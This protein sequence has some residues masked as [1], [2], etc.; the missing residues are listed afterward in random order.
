VTIFFNRP[1]AAVLL[2]AVVLSLVLPF[3]V[4]IRSFFQRRQKES[5]AAAQ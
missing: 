1:I 4:G 3:V 5:D 2:V